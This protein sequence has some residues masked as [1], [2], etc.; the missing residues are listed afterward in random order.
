MVK[1]TAL[2]D[3]QVEIVAIVTEVN[4]FIET[5]SRTL[6]TLKRMSGKIANSATAYRQKIA[7]LEKQI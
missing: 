6:N 1:L 3:E 5:T 4:D 2:K 7:E